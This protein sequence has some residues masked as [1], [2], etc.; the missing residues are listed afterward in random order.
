[1]ASYGLPLPE[2]LFRRI[3]GHK[4]FVK[5]DFRAGFWQLNLSEEA[6]QHVAFHAPDSGKRLTYTRL[7][8]GHVNATALFQR[9]MEKELAT[10]S[11]SHYAAPFVDDVIMWCDSWEEIMSN[12]RQLLQHLKTVGLRLHPAKTI[13]VPALPGALGVSQ[14]VQARTSQDCRDQG[15]ATTQ[16]P[17]APASP[18]GLVQL[19]PL[20][21]SQLL[22][23]S[24]AA[25]QAYGKR[26]TLH[27]E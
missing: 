25:L 15:S 12:F 4:F 24:P 11:L 20:L 3:R 13:V 19:L 1:M 5:A 23:H 2:E 6:Q 18:P 9:V 8:F 22:H 14:G 21:R 16:Q 17:Q 7:C 27:L 10:A 26:S